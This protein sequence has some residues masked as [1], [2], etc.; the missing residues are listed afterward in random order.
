MNVKNS[1]FSQT[2]STFTH[3]MEMVP[4]AL[5]VHTDGIIHYLNPAGTK[6][7]GGGGNEDIA[8]KNILFFFHPDNREQ[9]QVKL[10]E[11]F[12]GVGELKIEEWIYDVNGKAIFAELISKNVLF[13]GKPAILTT[14]YDITEFKESQID[15]GLSQEHYRSLLSKLPDFV[16]IQIENKIVYVNESILKAGG[17]DQE[18]M[19]NHT[20]FEFIDEK[21]HKKVIESINRRLSGSEPAPIEIE[22]KLKSGERITVLTKGELIRFNNK[23]AL[24]IVSVDISQRR[25]NEEKLKLYA[26]ELKRNKELLEEKAEQLSRSEDELKKLNATKDKFFSIIAHDLRG[27][28]NGLLGFSDFLLNEVD[29]LEK[30]EIRQF[31]S[32]ING[33]AHVLFDLLNNLLEWSRYQIEHSNPNPAKLNLSAEV[34]E[35]LRILSRNIEEKFQNV[36]T[37]INDSI[38]VY[39]DRHMFRSIV[40]N[41][42]ANAIKFT[43]EGGTIIIS[44]VR[45][46]GFAEISVIDRGTGMSEATLSR[47]FKLD[48]T[49]TSAG[50]NNEKGTGLG[51]VLCKEFIEKNGGTINVKSELNNGTQF[52]FTIPLG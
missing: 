45:C 43:P 51:L 41:L 31:A 36:T 38:F 12:R 28:F 22:I 19:L 25:K 5:C 13:K 6:L 2:E 26:E 8:G 37:D 17:Y 29:T 16:F 9:I 40:Q 14:I 7:L 52:T 10:K 44:A 23:N 46:G 30:E 39:A 11:L 35:T 48:E 47:L 4:V 20:V 50:T 21:Y 33:S 24:L 18:D 32:D 15:L 1:K 49:I 34:N 42:T 3:L 27:P